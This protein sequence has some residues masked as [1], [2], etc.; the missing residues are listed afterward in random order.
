MRTQGAFQNAKPKQH[1]SRRGI[2]K[3]EDCE[4]VSEDKKNNND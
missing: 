3:S 1:Y 2:P 4:G